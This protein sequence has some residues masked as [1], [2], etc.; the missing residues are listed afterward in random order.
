MEG[1]F[2]VDGRGKRSPLT[3]SSN[4]CCH[5]NPRACSHG[6]SVRFRT[7]RVNFD[8]SPKHILVWSEC[9]RE[10]GLWTISLLCDA[11]NENGGIEFGAAFIFS[12][13]SYKISNFLND[14]FVLHRYHFRGRHVHFRI[15]T[16]AFVYPRNIH[17]SPQKSYTYLSIITTMIDRQLDMY[18]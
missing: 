6:D 11:N 5:R 12:V 2:V 10:T 3:N 8:R 7:L 14:H 18:I 16:S 9:I 4:I 15:S 17:L 1:F 13:D